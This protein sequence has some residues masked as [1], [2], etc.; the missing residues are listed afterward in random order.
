MLRQRLLEVYLVFLIP[1][2][3]GGHQETE[4]SYRTGRDE[5]GLCCTMA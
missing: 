2:Q 1:C 3:S 4:S 5:S